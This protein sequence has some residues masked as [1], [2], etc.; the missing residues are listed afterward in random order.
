MRS[1]LNKCLNMHAGRVRIGA[2]ADKVRLL[3]PVR[4]HPRGGLPG[5]GAPHRMLEVAR[6]ISTWRAPA[7]CRGRGHERLAEARPVVI[8]CAAG[9]GR[10]P[11]ELISQGRYVPW[12]T[13]GCSP[14]PRKRPV[15]H[16]RG[17]HPV[18]LQGD[19][20]TVERTGAVS[21]TMV[22]QAGKRSRFHLQPA[23]GHAA[24]GGG[25]PAVDGGADAAGAG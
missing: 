24:H 19:R 12:R 16:G 15:G 6:R 7:T 3:R 23:R 22:F 13:A 9:R 14:T 2:Q 10:E 21:S 4:L 25:L 5:R 20:A 17:L 18:M 8:R 11:M 1:L